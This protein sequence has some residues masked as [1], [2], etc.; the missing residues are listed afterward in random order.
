[1][2]TSGGT[3]G[4]FLIGNGS[5]YYCAGF[6]TTQVNGGCPAPS[7]VGSVSTGTWTFLV[8]TYD[9]TTLRFYIDGTQVAEQAAPGV[10]VTGPD[11][12]SGA[13]G[14]SGFV[15]VGVDP[16]Y[17]GDFVNGSVADVAIYNAALSSAQIE[18]QY[19]QAELGQ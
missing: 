14:S 4:G 2:V 11:G 1:M 18:T 8:G 12:A 13:C 17:C 19:Q 15:A 3:G 5:Q 6:G 7:G 9:G 10:V 16:N